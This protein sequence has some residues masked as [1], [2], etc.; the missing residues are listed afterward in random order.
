LRLPAATGAPADDFVVAEHKS[1]S[2]DPSKGKQQAAASVAEAAADEKKGGAKERLPV[3]MCGTNHAHTARFPRKATVILAPTPRLL[4][5]QSI[6][7]LLL[8]SF[9]C[10][11]PAPQ[12]VAK[13]GG[14]CTTSAQRRVR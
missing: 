1:M 12:F 2:A 5:A 6:G 10:P 7:A 14:N 13:R 3:H 8:T 9:A 11:I 4:S